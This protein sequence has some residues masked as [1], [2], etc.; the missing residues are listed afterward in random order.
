MDEKKELEIVRE[1]CTQLNKDGISYCQWKSNNALDRSATGEN[2]LDLLVNRADLQTFTG[3]LTQLGFKQA[4][5]RWRQP[6]PGII[7]YYGFDRDTGR[8][9]HVHAHSQLILGHD[10]TKN[11]RIPIEES[12]LASASLN[13][14][15]MVPAAEF[16]LIILVIRLIIKHFT[17][18]T[19]VL[20]QGKLS[21]S[22]KAEIN[23]LLKHTSEER[24]FDVLRNNFEFINIQIFSD[25]LKGLTS[26][27]SVWKKI[28]VA[29][30]L[31][32]CIEPFARFPRGKDIWLKFWHRFYWPFRK[33]IQHI[34]TRKQMNSGGLMIAIVGG[35][36]AG[37]TTAIQETYRWL[38]GVFS[39]YSFHM[40][41]PKWSFLTRI[42]RGILKIGRSLGF[43]PFA[44]AENQYTNDP[45]TLSFPGYPYLI[46]AACTARDRYLTY[47]RAR[48]LATNGALVILDRFPLSQIKFMDGP[49]IAYITANHPQNRFVKFLIKMEENFYQK[50]VLPDQLIV[51]R[52]DPEIAVKRK[53]EEDEFSVRARS[54]E[55][56]EMDWKQTQ[57][58]VINANKPKE[59]VSAVIK[60]LIWSIL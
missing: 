11:Y 51:L 40:G 50:M 8:L 38:S 20:R 39:I 2:D 49:H 59:E 56:W 35:D 26:D 55:I 30:D 15:F 36:G 33:R 10:A 7:N 42:I 23:F 54:S 60:N 41:K 43:Y 4:F 13:G 5:E 34:D 3:I 45:D 44:R 29:Q 27:F 28:K 46:R 47:V 37:K 9:I 31:L 19:V 21:A 1:L 22:E 53:T 18:D 6:L 48:R 32:N 58:S 16:E 17:W 14:L 24:L 12:Y 25:C 52:A 57:A